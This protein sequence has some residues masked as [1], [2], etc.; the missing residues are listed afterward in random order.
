MADHLN[1]PGAFTY[2]RV[3]PAPKRNKAAV[4][5]S[6]TVSLL[7]SISE[8]ENSNNG[9]LNS[10][11]GD[12]PVEAS[13]DD[14]MVQSTSTSEMGKDNVVGRIND[15]N[16]KSTFVEP[17][18]IEDTESSSKNA[19]EEATNIKNEEN[20]DASKSSPNSTSSVAIAID[21]WKQK[22]HDRKRHYYDFDRFMNEGIAP[23]PGNLS[24]NTTDWSTIKVQ[25]DLFDVAVRILEV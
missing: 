7:N 14:V 19:E 1:I 5:A 20:K 17:G 6:N 2:L 25:H 13:V 11:V 12:V 10:K 15:D 3:T 16:M 24:D 18:S 21:I 23:D 8:K 22:N 4:G 9:K